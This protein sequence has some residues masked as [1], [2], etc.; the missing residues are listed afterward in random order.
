MPAL[1]EDSVVELTGVTV[2]NNFYVFAGLDDIAFSPRG[3]GYRYDRSTKQ[4]VKLPK[5]CQ[6]LPSYC[7]YNTKWQDLY[8][9]VGF[10]KPGEDK[11]WNPLPNSW[12]YSLLP[13]NGGH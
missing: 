12:E 6:F 3:L 8:I 9:L 5:I 13:M 1:P 7:S 4:W 11:V 10:N 2:G